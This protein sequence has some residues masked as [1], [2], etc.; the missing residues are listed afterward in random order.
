MGINMYILSLTTNTQVS[1]PNSKS[2]T[3]LMSVLPPWSYLSPRDEQKIPLGLS[4]FHHFTT[5]GNYI[6]YCF[7]EHRVNS[8]TRQIIF[9]ELHLLLSMFV[10]FIFVELRSWDSFLLSQ[11]SIEHNVIN[12]LPCWWAFELLRDICNYNLYCHELSCACLCVS[13]Q[14]VSLGYTP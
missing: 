7:F 8:I 14:R 6:Y 9:G 1:L 13:V 2:N 11:F 3:S 12:L 10:R 4:S 5:Y